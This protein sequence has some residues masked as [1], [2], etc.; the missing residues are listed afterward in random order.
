[1][2]SGDESSDSDFEW[3]YENPKQNNKQNNNKNIIDKN[4]IDKNIIDLDYRTKKKF[5]L[6]LE[7]A[8]TH[9]IQINDFV[10]GD[11]DLSYKNIISMNIHKISHL[12]PPCEYIDVIIPSLPIDSCISNNS[13]QHIVARING[14]KNIGETLDTGDYN[15]VHQLM[16]FSPPININFKHFKILFKPHGITQD[17]Y[18]FLNDNPTEIYPMNLFFKEYHTAHI[19]ESID[20]DADYNHSMW[21]QLGI[22]IKNNNYI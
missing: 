11:Y 3:G 8:S 14:S 10:G 16:N 22:T 9:D 13:K 6:L 15:N 21:I 4:I 12:M 5:T 1:M 20:N 18:K 2:N 19:G 17:S 7:H